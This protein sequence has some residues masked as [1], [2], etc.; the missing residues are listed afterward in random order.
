MMMINIV[1]KGSS[2][3]IEAQFHYQESL[4]KFAQFD[5][6]HTWNFMFFHNEKVLHEPSC[7]EPLTKR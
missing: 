2:M 1:A 5:L 3:G 7:H 4:T 6:Y